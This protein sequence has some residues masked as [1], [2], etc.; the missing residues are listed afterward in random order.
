M[1]L[2]PVQFTLHVSVLVE[3]W[4]W[5]ADSRAAE[6]FLIEDLGSRRMTVYT[7]DDYLIRIYE[8]TT[9]DYRAFNRDPTH[10]AIAPEF[11]NQVFDNVGPFLN[12]FVVTGLFEVIAVSDVLRAAY[13]LALEHDIS[14]A[15]GMSVALAAASSLPLLI[16][17]RSV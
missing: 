17:D 13:A 6:S 14:L 8:A 16:A 7:L 12:S 4:L 2:V 11:T 9:D 5:G 10:D 1:A 3:C 15:D